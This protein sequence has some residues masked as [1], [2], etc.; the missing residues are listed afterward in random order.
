L[1]IWPTSQGEQQLSWREKT[2]S[3]GEKTT[4]LEVENS[5]P[6]GTTA[7]LGKKQLPRWN[8]I[9]PGEKQ[10]PREYNSFPGGITKILGEKQLPRGNNSYPGGKNSFPW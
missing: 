2:A 10:L 1:E 6:G 4:I 5:F 3:Q 8:N 7:I 9:Y